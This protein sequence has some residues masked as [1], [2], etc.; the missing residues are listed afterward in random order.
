MD[1]KLTESIQA[2]LNEPAE[3]RDLQAG[4]TLV[5]RLTGNRFMYQNILG[6]KDTKMIDYQLKRFLSR[7]LQEFTHEQVV[8]MKR[9]AA[10]IAETHHLDTTRKPAKTLADEWKKGKREDHD[11]LPEEIQALYAE[12]LTILH[13]MRECHLQ[14]RKIALSPSSCPDGDIYPFVKELITLDKQYHTN[15]QTY[16]EYGRNGDADGSSA[17][18]KS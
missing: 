8:E 17:E 18:N 6:R 1:N 4:A 2:Y 16:D 12:N 5:L 7:R 14:A 9:Q 10:V 3:T 11:S 13:R 15:W